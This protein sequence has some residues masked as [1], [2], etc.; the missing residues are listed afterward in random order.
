MQPSPERLKMFD[1]VSPSNFALFK[2][3]VKF[4]EEVSRL[5]DV[6]RPFDSPVGN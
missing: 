4:P 1:M 5:A 2:I 6:T 3:L